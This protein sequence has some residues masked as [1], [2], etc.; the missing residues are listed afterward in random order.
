MPG[1]IWNVAYKQ[2]LKGTEEVKS[3]E[4]LSKAAVNE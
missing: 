1:L 2:E 3:I 4:A